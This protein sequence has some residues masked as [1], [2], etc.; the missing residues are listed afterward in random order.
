LDGRELHAGS[1]VERGKGVVGGRTFVFSGKWGSF[2]VTGRA[3]RGGGDDSAAGA[4]GVRLPAASARFWGDFHPTSRFSTV[5]SSGHCSSDLRILSRVFL[6]RSGF[7]RSRI[8]SRTYRGNMIV[9][10]VYVQP[11][12][13]MALPTASR[14]A[15]LRFERIGG[16]YWSIW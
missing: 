9:D 11:P 16:S 7:A 4:L 5:W 10:F 1:I 2:G 15:T 6:T 8:A 14:G 12:R 13:K 3:G